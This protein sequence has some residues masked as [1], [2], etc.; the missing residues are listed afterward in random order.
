MNSF[1]II[2][3]KTGIVENIELHLLVLLKYVGTQAAQAP[4]WM[5]ILHNNSHSGII[6]VCMGIFTT[7][8]RNKKIHQI[9]KENTSPYFHSILL[10]I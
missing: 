1:I 4:A 5:I 7:V 10:V 6:R 3:Y 2:R 9:L 8:L